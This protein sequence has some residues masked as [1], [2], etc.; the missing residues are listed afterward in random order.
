[1]L[2]L[3]AKNRWTLGLF[4]GFAVALSILLQVPILNRTY[5]NVWFE[6]GTRFIIGFLFF[7]FILPLIFKKEWNNR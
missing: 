1:M 6:A 3:I 2:N 4:G 5:D 7:A